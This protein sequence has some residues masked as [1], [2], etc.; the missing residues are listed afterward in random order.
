MTR[1]ELGKAQ[2]KDEATVLV[3]GPR[4]GLL[5]A[6]SERYSI[7]PPKSVLRWVLS[8]ARFLVR[9]DHVVF[10]H[11]SSG[12]TVGAVQEIEPTA[13]RLVC[14]IVPSVAPDPFDGQPL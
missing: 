7:R 11:H 9:V 4:F 8:P 5:C 12:R 13:R 6:E 1:G 2:R 3:A 14:Q 10:L